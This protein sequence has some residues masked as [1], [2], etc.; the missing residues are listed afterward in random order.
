MA[1]LIGCQQPNNIKLAEKHIFLMVLAGVK[2]KLS[3]PNSVNSKAESSPLFLLPYNISTLQS[4]EKCL[5][6]VGWAVVE[7][8]G[9]L[10]TWV[11][12]KHFRPKN[13]YNSTWMQRVGEESRLP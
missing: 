11:P 1:L 10:I 12:K 13:I 9:P 6:L 7:R 8:R 2:T 5:I 3:I 4:G